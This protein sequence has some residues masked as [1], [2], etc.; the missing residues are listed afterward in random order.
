MASWVG[1]GTTIPQSLVG[2]SWHHHSTTESRHSTTIPPQSLAIPPPFHPKVSPFHHSTPKSRQSTTIPPQR[3]AI[4][5]PFHPKV[6]PFHH[7]STLGGG[8]GVVVVVVVGVGLGFGVGVGLLGGSWASPESAFLRFS[9]FLGFAR[10]SF[11]FVWFSF[12]FPWFSFGVGVGVGVFLWVFLGFPW[13]SLVFL[14]GWCSGTDVFV[15]LTKGF[16]GF[17]RFFFGFALFSWLGGLRRAPGPFSWA[18]IGLLGGVLAP[19]GRLLGAIWRLLGASWLPLGG[20]RAG[21]P[22]NCDS[23]A[24]FSH[25]R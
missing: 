6:S 14:L 15:C 12:G 17:P 9:R 19:S 5:P 2:G 1:P 24:L 16:L 8:V 10:F 7:H 3:R 22:Q 18:W 4:P 11:G 13:F 25:F 23:I 21:N 20:T